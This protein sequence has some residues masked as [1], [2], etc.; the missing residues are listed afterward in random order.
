MI[1]LGLLAEA[2]RAH[3]DLQADRFDVEMSDATGGLA[4]A[5]TLRVAG[6]DALEFYLTMERLR[7]LA[8]V[9]A[10]A[11][12]YGIPAEALERALSGKK[13]DRHG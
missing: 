13:E 10:L 1:A 7:D 9:R 2:L 12:R 6:L 5:V 11:E 3:G 4:V 8:T